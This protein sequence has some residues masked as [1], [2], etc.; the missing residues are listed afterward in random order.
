[1]ND[2]FWKI[3]AIAAIGLL[4]IIAVLL[5]LGLRRR[6][7]P[8]TSIV[9][10]KPAE[11]PSAPQYSGDATLAAIQMIGSVNDSFLEIVNRDGIDSL[12]GRAI[13]HRELAQACNGYAA[14]L[15]IFI[16]ADI[17]P[18]AVSFFR[19]FAEFYRQYADLCSDFS[20]H[21]TRIVECD[22]RNSGLGV[23][24]EGAIRGALGDPFGK[25]REIQAEHREFDAES[26]ALQK[27]V[28]TLVGVRNGLLESLNSVV[29][30]LAAKYEWE[31]E[32]EEA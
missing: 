7:E 23:I 10:A 4:A 32:K 14:K 2:P 19:P 13:Q 5:V 8:V 6:R 17:D 31:T 27:R 1:M 28:D 18:K 15:S 22:S 30:L 21:F 9:P 12:E 16:D 24:F 26:D 11:I 29:G 25:R 3:I 20:A